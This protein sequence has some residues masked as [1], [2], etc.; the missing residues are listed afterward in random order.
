MKRLSTIIALAL[1]I[2]IGGVFA[3]WH[4][5][6]SNT[7]TE[8][9]R[10]G[11]MASVVVD[12]TMGSIEVLKDSNGEAR[13]NIKFL[14]DDP[15]EMDRVAELVPSGSAYIQFTPSAT[16]ENDVITKRY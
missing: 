14:I 10:S 15:D 4:Y 8:I 11:T 13:N 7:S 16:A 3:A 6:D 2:T 12:G 1:V 9:T 5:S